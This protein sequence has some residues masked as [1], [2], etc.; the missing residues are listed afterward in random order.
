MKKNIKKY[1]LTS[2]HSHVPTLSDFFNWPWSLPFH[3]YLLHDNVQ[4]IIRMEI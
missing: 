4:H 2:P 3:G 1:L